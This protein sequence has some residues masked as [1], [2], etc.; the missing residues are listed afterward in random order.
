MREIICNQMKEI[1]FIWT[2]ITL[3]MVETGVTSIWS[4]GVK[5]VHGNQSINHCNWWGTQL[6][7]YTTT[8]ITHMHACML[9]N[10]HKFCLWFLCLLVLRAKRKP[11]QCEHSRLQSGRTEPAIWLINDNDHKRQWNQRE[12][13]GVFGRIKMPSRAPA[14]VSVPSDHLQNMEVCFTQF[15]GAIHALMHQ[16][17]TV[18]SRHSSF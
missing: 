7:V 10:T 5:T 11:E 18:R 4:N 8:S 13:V 1:T 14:W 2:V 6:A 9:I 16:C 17:F 15:T 3:D 12:G